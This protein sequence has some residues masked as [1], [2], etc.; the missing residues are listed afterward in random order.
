MVMAAYTNQDFKKALQIMLGLDRKI[1]TYDNN[2][3]STFWIELMPSSCE[4]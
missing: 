1:V 3:G 4:T 2:C